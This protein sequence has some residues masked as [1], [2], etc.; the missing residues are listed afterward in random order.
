[1]YFPSDPMFDFD[2]IFQSIVDP[3]ARRLLIADYDHDLT[4][5]EYA[6]GYRWDI[7]LSGGHRTWTQ[8]D[9]D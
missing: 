3:A 8:G 5:P 2:P 1:M 4:E 6:T 7:V 9:D